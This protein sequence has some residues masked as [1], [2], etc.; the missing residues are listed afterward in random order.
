MKIVIPQNCKTKFKIFGDERWRV[1]KK[2][3]KKLIKN[4]FSYS[5]EHVSDVHTA[6][7]EDHWTE[8][9]ITEYLTTKYYR[10]SRLLW[11]SLS[12]IF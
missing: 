1:N 11:C 4:G 7:K 3:N 8:D 10:R 12:L 2:V 9:T 5:E 6:N